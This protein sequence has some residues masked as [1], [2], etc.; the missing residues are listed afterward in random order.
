MAR[1]DRVS[2]ALVRRMDHYFN[3][4]D[5]PPV[6][7][8]AGGTQLR[9]GMGLPPLDAFGD[10]SLPWVMSGV[11]GVTTS[12]PTL[13]VSSDCRGRIMAEFSVGVARCSVALGDNGELPSL[14][15]MEAEYARQEDDKDR[16]WLAT[17]TAMKEL[18]DDFQIKDYALGQVEV[19]GPQ[20]GTVAVYRTIMVAL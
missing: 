9:P 12:F 3:N 1:T 14:E 10:C 16:L 15:T 2:E 18:A 8:L 19:H 13:D 11:L 4:A 5:M 6:G 7:G 17:C 20:G